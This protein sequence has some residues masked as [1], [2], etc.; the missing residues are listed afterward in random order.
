MGA[1]EKDD[2]LLK[3]SIA[4]VSCA[5]TS[6]ILNPID[7]SKIKMQVS[8]QGNG[9]K[10]QMMS[11]VKVEG[12]RGLTRGI[13]PSVGRELIYG[14][15]RIGGYEPV[16]RSFAAVYG[17]AGKQN[18]SPFVKYGSALFS[19]ALGSTFANPFD[20]VKTR[21]QAAV[22][23]KGDSGTG[24]P[25]RNTVQ[26]FSYIVKNEGGIR[27]LYR[28]VGPTIARAALVTSSQLGTYDSV[29][30]NLLKAQFGMEEGYPLHCASAFAA[31]IAIT[32][33]SN[34]ADVVKSR[35]MADASSGGKG[36][37]A[38]VLDCIKEVLEE[39]AFYRGATA[40]Y[41]RFAP[42]TFLSLL[43]VEKIR[44]LLGLD[45]I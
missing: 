38:S 41:S 22:V 39:R 19:G 3:A 12:L 7:V 32:I 14:T 16:L 34:P 35:Y 25:Y 45:G 31:G 37:Y 18:T 4:G 36:R 8:G 42:H 2:K 5:G 13:E 6:T 10:S 27:A 29:K 40:A 15:I 9:L 43:A 17:G 23:E 44:Q 28:G 20:L 1:I 33:A 30:N 24:Y 11:I 21:F 26:A